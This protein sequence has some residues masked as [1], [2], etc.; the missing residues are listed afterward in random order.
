MDRKQLNLALQAFFTAYRSARYQGIVITVPSESHLA[1]LCGQIEAILLEHD[2]WQQPGMGC[3]PNIP[4][5]RRDFMDAVFLPRPRGLVI[6]SPMEWMIDW[7]EQDQ[8]TLWTGIADAFGRHDIL[9]LS[10][11]TRSVTAQLRV[12]LA[13]HGLPGVP[14][15]V[16]LS[17]HQPLDLLEGVLA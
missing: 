11:A 3:A 15:S 4:C 1:L 17:R 8:A 2:I 5:G 12:S 14:V 10:V 7:P 13:E 16:W 6:V 9:G